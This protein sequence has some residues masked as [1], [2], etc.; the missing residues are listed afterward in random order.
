MV[1]L[2]RV[3]R[4][5]RSVYAKSIGIVLNSLIFHLCVGKRELE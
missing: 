3:I 5:T 4:T 1:L 2:A